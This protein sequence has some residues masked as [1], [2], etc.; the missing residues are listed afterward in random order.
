MTRPFRFGIQLA[1]PLPGL[2]WA[3]T[4]RKVES[5]GFSSL[6]VPDHFGE[7]WGPIVAMTAAASATTEL[8]VGCL[9]FDNDY[10]H[11]ITLGK[12]MATLACEAPGRV[13][14]GLGAGWMRWDY[15]RAGMEYDAPKV[16][17]DR[18]EEG[19]GIII[20]TVHG[21]EVTAS[22]D[23]YEVDAYPAF[24]V[25]DVPPA[26]MIG[27]GGPRMLRIAAERADIVAITARIPS[28]V[29][30]VKSALDS[31]P[32]A[33]DQKI[34]WVKEAAG[35]RWGGFDLNCLVFLAAVTE[36]SRSMAEG[37]AAMFGS[38]P[39]VERA[40]GRSMR[41]AAAQGGPA[42]SGDE[43]GPDGFGVDD[44]LESP[45]TLL[46][47]IGEMADRLEQ[48]RDR[49]GFNYV[50]FQGEDSVDQLAPLVARLAGR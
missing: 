50:V 28:G 27:G 38:E 44:V 17:V 31:A 49:W 43:S 3:E 10:R 11:P 1:S 12:E 48:R 5:A 9:V 7:Q 40:V 20:D 42:G 45:A 35:D 15:E 24:P 26:I 37:V 18:F 16:R 41:D 22:G 2:T 6:V 25:P 34:R 46:G 39:Q 13:E 30:D 4:A 21:R 23:H 33:V 29:V 19:L 14:L 32:S 8:T 36:D 47:T